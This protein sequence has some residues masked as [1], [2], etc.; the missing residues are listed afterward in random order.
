[1]PGRLFVVDSSPAVHR[2]VEQASLAHGYDVMAFKE[3]VAALSAAKE[4]RP[5]LYIVDYHL[6]G[7]EFLAFC[8]RLKKAGLLPDAAVISLVNFSDRVDE[9]HLR[10]LGVRAFLKKPL[11]PDNLLQV[12]KNLDLGG[13]GNEAASAVSG[14]RGRPVEPEVKA[15]AAATTEAGSE[16][17]R[18]I[19]KTPSKHESTHPFKASVVGQKADPLA[20]DALRTLSSTL[21]QLVGTQA[22]QAVSQALPDLVARE[23]NAR[24]GQ[25]VRAEVASQIAAALPKEQMA[26]LA[27]KA[28]QKELPAAVAK[29]LA[30]MGPTLQRTMIESASPIIKD[31]T[32]KLIKDQAEPAVKKHLPELMKQQLGSLEALV[33]EAAQEA[34]AR[35]VREPAADIVR[36]MAKEAVDQAVKKVVPDLAE[37]VIKKEIERLTASA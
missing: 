15:A 20:E 27:M 18:Q 32:G 31:L 35:Y 19:S 1:M 33:K 7:V 14:D 13:S 30:E 5:E 34:A 25:V 9:D 37:S 4:H 6:E 36:E 29:H 22:E 10:S 23:V 8:E 21:L 16:A 3:G 11:Q 28:V 17:S 24:L 2:L 26:E 12:M